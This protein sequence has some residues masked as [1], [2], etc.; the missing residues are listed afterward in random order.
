[1]NKSQFAPDIDF[2]SEGVVQFV[3][4]LKPD[5]SPY[6]WKSRPNE[7]VAHMGNE[8][9]PNDDVIS[10][11]D[12]TMKRIRMIA[13]CDT[14]D[15]NEQLR[16][17]SAYDAKYRYR[18]NDKMEIVNGLLAV[19]PKKEPRKM[20]Y[21]TICNY[22]GSNPNRDPNVRILFYLNDAAAKA[23]TD[24]AKVR[25]A[26]KAKGLILSLEGNTR[27]QVDICKLLGLDEHMTEEQILMELRKRAETNPDL[28]IN[29]ITSDKMNAELIVVKGEQF[30]IIEFRDT[31]Y[32]YCGT[33]DL[34][35]GFQGKQKQDVA[36]KKFIEWL[37]TDDGQAHLLN[38]QQMI[39][40]KEA[41]TS[42]KLKS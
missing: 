19:V 39:E 1:M 2:T 36:R 12:G 18:P 41:E 22:N 29:A 4:A 35:K 3:T 34:I 26:D 40:A 20:E 38:I 24:Y 6:T 8:T 7:R 30:G 37:Q 23:K 15:Y 27:K 25:Q 21:L 42:N 9:I 16:K 31:K 5:E 14:L 10:M 32:V 11:P 33:D 13:S 28:V 17:G